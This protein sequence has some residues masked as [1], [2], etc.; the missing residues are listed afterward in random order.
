MAD[1][2]EE[3]MQLTAVLVA[4]PASSHGVVLHVRGKWM[5]DHGVEVAPQ[6]LAY[7]EMGPTDVL[8]L[9]RQMIDAGMIGEIGAEPAEPQAPA[10]P[11]RILRLQ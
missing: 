11:A 3:P 1:E 10:E 9:F 4:V 5:T 2:S 7:K 8:V 6:T